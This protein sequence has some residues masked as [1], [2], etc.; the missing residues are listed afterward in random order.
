MAAATGGGEGV[1]GLRRSVVDEQGGLGDQRRSASRRAP[2]SAASRPVPGA[3][4]RVNLPQPGDQR[5][6]ATPPSARRTARA[7]TVP[8]PTTAESS[9][10]ARSS[11]GS[12]GPR[13]YPAASYTMVAAPPGTPP[14]GMG[15][16]VSQLPVLGSEFV[17]PYAE[18]GGAHLVE[19]LAQTSADGLLVRVTSAHRRRFSSRTISRS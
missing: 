10:A 2:A 19:L 12:P 16:V 8:P 13:A 17:H 7:C 4:G 5:A 1:R 3:A 9:D 11:R 18:V 6:P 15:E 14:L